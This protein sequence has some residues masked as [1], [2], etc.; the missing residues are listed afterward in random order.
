MQEKI[1]KL[2]SL[3]LLF[4]ED[5]NDLIEIIS[6]TLFKLDAN[7][8]TAKNGVEALE[9]IEK[10]PDIDI[11]L[12]DINMPIM[13]GLVMIEKL[14]ERNNK[15]PIIVTSAHTEIDYINKAKNLGVNNY[16]LKPFDFINVINLIT[17][18]EL[19]D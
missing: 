18:M 4:V 2:R 5:E 7:F 14:K 9:I 8:L 13:N 17:S 19:E 12:T 11:I 6:D 16:L 15:I 10:N 1:E 3:K